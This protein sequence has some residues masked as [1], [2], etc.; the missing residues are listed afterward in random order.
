MF[1]CE[2]DDEHPCGSKYC[3]RCNYVL[4]Y[5]CKKCNYSITYVS[6]YNEI[7]T[8]CSKCSFEEIVTVPPKK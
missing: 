5:N 1:S 4:W 2:Y 6:F 3:I 8:K 7:P